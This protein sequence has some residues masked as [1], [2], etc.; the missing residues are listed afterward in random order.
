MPA[1]ANALGAKLEI[2]HSETLQHLRHAA[3]QNS[4]SVLLVT[5]KASIVVTWRKSHFLIALK[6]VAVT[7]VTTTMTTKTMAMTTTMERDQVLAKLPKKQSG[8][9]VVMLEWHWS[10][11]IIIVFKQSWNL[12]E[13]QNSLNLLKR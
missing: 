12:A 11:I 5:G 10:K 13:R 1:T 6:M 8:D 7:I 9:N 2:S 3:I 4:F